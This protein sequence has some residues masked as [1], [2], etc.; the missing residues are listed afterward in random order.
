MISNNSS[1]SSINHLDRLAISPVLWDDPFEGRRVA[2]HRVV[3]TAVLPT[4]NHWAIRRL[5]RWCPAVTSPSGMI[6]S[7][8][9]YH[10]VIIIS[11]YF[12]KER[13]FK[14]FH[15][16]KF[17]FFVGQRFS[18]FNVSSPLSDIVLSDKTNHLKE[19]IFF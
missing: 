10:Q 19:I 5:D 16:L 13:Q 1:K 7:D 8:A 3:A 14:D 4:I 12:S 15:F 2:C 17:K 11:Y 6:L 9:G 18:Q